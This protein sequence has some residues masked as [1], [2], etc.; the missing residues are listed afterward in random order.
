MPPLAPRQP[1]QPLQ[2]DSNAMPQQPFLQ[3]N[4]ALPLQQSNAGM[5]PWMPTGAPSAQPVA[6][7]GPPQTTQGIRHVSN[8][9]RD[10]VGMGA[11]GRHSPD[12][13]ASLSAQ[14]MR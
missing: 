5:N 7:V 11:G 2:E 9:S 12:A 14:Y 3:G 13:F 1:L 6:P 4:A 8:D 10:F